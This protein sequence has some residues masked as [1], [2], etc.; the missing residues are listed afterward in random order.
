MHMHKDIA[1]SMILIDNS[2]Y[3]NNSTADQEAIREYI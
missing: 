3:K 2:Q 1:M